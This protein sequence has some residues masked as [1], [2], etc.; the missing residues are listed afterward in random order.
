MFLAGPASP[1]LFCQP[2]IAVRQGTRDLPDGTGTYDFGSVTLYASTSTVTFS[3]DNTGTDPLLLSGNPKISLSGADPAMFAIVTLPPTAIAPAA[4]A[5]FGIS[6]SPG[7]VRACSAIVSIVNND[8]DEFN[9]TFNIAGTGTAQ[10]QADPPAFQ[11]ASGTYDA[12]QDVQMTTQTPAATIFY[13]LDNSMPAHDPNGMPLGTTQTYASAVHVDQQTRIRA[14]TYRSLTVDSNVRDS[15][16]DFRPGA[17]AFTPGPGRY[18]S[19]Q[20]LT[21]TTSTAGAQILYTADGS[22]PS[23]DASGNPTGT[24]RLFIGTVAIPVSETIRAIAYKRGY[25]DSDT[26]E[27]AYVLAA[28]QPAILPA[29]PT[30]NQ[31]IHITITTPTPGASIYYTVDGTPPTSSSTVYPAGGFSLTRSGTVSA[32]AA[33]AGWSPSDAAQRTY[34][35]KA[36]APSISPHGGTYD[37]VQTLT[38]QPPAS[39]LDAKIR[40]VI[41][42]EIVQA[43]TTASGTLYAG[44]FRLPDA[45]VM[46]VKAIA[47]KDGWSASEAATESYTFRIP[48]F[49][50]INEGPRTTFLSKGPFGLN[51]SSTWPSSGYYASAA[52]DGSGRCVAVGPFGFIASTTNGFTWTAAPAGSSDNIN[53]VAYGENRWISVGARG[54]IR[55]SDNGGAA[56]TQISSGVSVELQGITHVP[57]RFIAVGAGGTVLYSAD[58]GMTWTAASS[59][60]TAILYR[61]AYAVQTGRLIAV[62]LGGALVYSDDLGTSWHTAVSGTTSH[63]HGI[64][65]GAGKWLAVGLNGEIRSSTDNGM[66]WQHVASGTTYYL[67]G[68]GYSADAGYWV[69]VGRNNTILYSADTITW[70]STGYPYFY[71]YW[72]VVYWN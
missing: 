24:T 10:P 67:L 11:P 63:L 47:Y 51:I 21:L 34:S 22:A 27:A 61:V 32:I 35:L 8:P 37:T 15:F 49:I 52:C 1:A 30:S 18:S 23:H 46:T 7:S 38:I 17:P 57:G 65:Y 71:D 3:I 69:A 60:T 29:T 41:G 2:E 64:A 9:Y 59:G 36:D 6:F 58:R 48:H 12:P 4:S 42:N 39:A 40:Y 62:G 50:A 28:E 68:V 26:A 70:R 5:S 53:G 72:D 56:W 43:P 20:S 55:Y 33:K 13:T 44:P 19:A 45:V 16:Y 25:P 14:L 66:T 31:P 54:I